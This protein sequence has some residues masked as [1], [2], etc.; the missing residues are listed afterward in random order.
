[1][2]R[3]P[4]RLGTVRCHRGLTLLEVVV[5]MALLG[6]GITGILG[7]MTSCL[8][9]SD[10]SLGY[11]RGVLLA[12]QVAAEL[13]R[14]ETLDPGELSGTFDELTP[15]YTW[16]ATIA[17]ANDQGLYPVEILVHWQEGT[18][19]YRMLT[20]LRPHVLPVAPEPVVNEDTSTGGQNGGTAPVTGGTQ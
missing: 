4:H 17:S 7:A 18:R 12:Q 14:N 19:Q 3:F 2:K 8:R 5:A 11:S 9:S 15:G 10:A 6:I 20:T 13:E 16:T 1:M